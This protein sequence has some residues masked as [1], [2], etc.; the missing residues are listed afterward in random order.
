MLA[1]ASISVV[2][3]VL[4]VTSMLAVFQVDGESIN[5]EMAAS[6]VLTYVGLMVM[7]S[8]LIRARVSFCDHFLVKRSEY[9]RFSMQSGVS[10]LFR[11]VR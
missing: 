1:T 3:V 4:V 7:A 8:I 9:S 11:Y 2:P 6:F 10:I 5:N